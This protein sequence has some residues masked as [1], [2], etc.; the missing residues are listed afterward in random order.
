ML[1][2]LFFLLLV[3]PGMQSISAQTRPLPVIDMHLH[4]LHADAQGP[5][6]I[7]VGA[8]FRDLGIHDP[9]EDYRETFM[10]ALKTNMWADSFLTSPST[11]DSLKQLTLSALR[12]N[13]V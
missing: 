3:N 13:N 4:A 2:K 1:R 9:K 8:P 11:D 10:K 7:S 6:P 5:P 12:R